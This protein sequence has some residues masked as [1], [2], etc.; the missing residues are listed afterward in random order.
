MAPPLPVF[1]LL[2]GCCCSAVGLGL[3]V[4]AAEGDVQDDTGRHDRDDGAGDQSRHP[5][6]HN[7]EEAEDEHGDGRPHHEQNLPW[8][9]FD[10]EG[11]HE[12]D[13]ARDDEADPDPLGHLELA[14]PVPSQQDDA[15]EDQDRSLDRHLESSGRETGDEDDRDEGDQEHQDVEHRE[16][17][18]RTHGDR[19]PVPQI[20]GLSPLVTGRVAVASLGRSVAVLG[21]RRSHLVV[22]GEALLLGFRRR[23]VRHR[24]GL[25]G[26]TAPEGGDPEEHPEKEKNE[27]PECPPNHEMTRHVRTLRGTHC[28]AKNESLEQ[29]LAA[30]FKLSAGPF[31]DQ[32]P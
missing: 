29:L 20:L 27:R 5:R 31:S 14:D 21:L 13:R 4:V 15:G 10:E 32:T 1:H 9:L 17:D 7:F 24:I 22:L 26:G 2:S 18:E 23:V 19:S 25:F 30:S 11:D 6:V 3:L 16:G 12:E 28:A 8:P